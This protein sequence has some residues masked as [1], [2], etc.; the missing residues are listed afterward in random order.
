MIRYGEKV[1]ASESTLLSMLKIYPFSYGLEIVQGEGGRGGG[2]GEGGA[3][4]C[5]WL[6]MMKTVGK[7]CNRIKNLKKQSIAAFLLM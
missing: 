5:V 6:Q 3:G 7:F 2:G 4:Q 1:G